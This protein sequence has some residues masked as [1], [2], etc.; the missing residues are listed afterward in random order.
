[1]IVR[2]EDHVPTYTATEERLAAIWRRALEL[3]HV[4]REDDFFQLGG[5]SLAAAQ[6]VFE[7]EKA[8]GRKLPL[9]VLQEA[10]TLNLLT[11][12]LE[13]QGTPGPLALRGGSATAGV[14]PTF[15]VRSWGGRVR[16]RLVE[17]A[18]RPTPR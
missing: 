18:A 5:D 3:E 15:L 12:H 4:D 10:P 14:E 7:I 13:R 2:Q 16:S 1:M 6:V 17:A 11:A 8:F 9:T